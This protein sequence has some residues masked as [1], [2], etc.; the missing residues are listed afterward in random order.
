MRLQWFSAGEDPP[1]GW[2]R[3][4]YWTGHATSALILF[5]ASM[6]S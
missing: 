3:R 4:E 2:A 5:A 1:L 6:T